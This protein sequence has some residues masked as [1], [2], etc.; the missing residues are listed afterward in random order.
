MRKITI[1]QSMIHQGNL[2]LVNHKNKV[3]EINYS[4]LIEVSHLYPNILLE[5]EAT[6]MLKGLMNSIDGW[7]DIALVSGWRSFKEQECIYNQSIAENGLEFTQK[8]VALPGCSEHQTGLAIDVGIIKPNIDFL[9]P[10]FPYEGIAQV[11]RKKAT[12]FGFIERYLKSKETITN[13]GC[14]PWHFRYVGL[15]HSLIIN[16][17]DIVLEEYIEF[18][19][20]YQYPEKKYWFS[21]NGIEGKISYIEI[22]EEKIIDVEEDVIYTISG[23]NQKGILLAE[24]QINE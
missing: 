3:N 7:S 5:H 21:I 6:E 14:E 1:N 4:K 15:P 20:E 23:D 12:A 19:H 22:K 9:C 13:I 2:I 17:K 18:I 16:E 11:F 10:E 8:F 24:W